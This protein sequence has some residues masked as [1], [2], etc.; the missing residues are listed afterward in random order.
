MRKFEE[1]ADNSKLHF[2]IAVVAL[3]LEDPP[4][5]LYAYS[6]AIDKDAY[7]AAAFFSRAALKYS[8]N[9]VEGALADYQD[10]YEV[11]V[12]LM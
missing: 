8:L 10:C 5:A 6:T 11:I 3:V 9:D 4:K 2:N 12:F 7:F 1:F